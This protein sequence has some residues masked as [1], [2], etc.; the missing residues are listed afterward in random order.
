MGN[1]DLMEIIKHLLTERKEL[2]EENHLLKSILHSNLFI[3]GED[4]QEDTETD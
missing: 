4:E 2:K 3:L 1:S